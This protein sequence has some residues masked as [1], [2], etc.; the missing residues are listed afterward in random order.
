[1]SQDIV[2]IVGGDGEIRTFLR[3]TVLSPAG[4]RVLMAADGQEGL[5]RT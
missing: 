5:E 1:M 2:L 3:E 4:Y